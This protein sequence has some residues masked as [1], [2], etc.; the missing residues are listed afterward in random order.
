MRN[1]KQETI[2]VT[3][4][5]GFLGSNVVRAVLDEGYRV[6][7]M[8]EPT[9]HGDALDGLEMETVRGS[10]L[11]AEF[12]SAAVQGTSGVIHTAASTAVWPERIPAMRA[13]NVDAATRI[14]T[15]AR[16]AG[17]RVFVHV[18]TASSF[19]WGPKEKPGDERGAYTSSRFGLDYLD[20]KHE[21]QGLMLA[22]DAPDFRVTVVNPTFMFGPYDSKPSSGAMILAIANQS[23]PGYT[24]GGRSFADVRAVAQGIVSSLE[25]GRG[26]QCYILGGQNLSYKE[27]FSILASVTNA[28]A[29]RL[30]MPGG[31]A[32]AYGALGSACSRVSGKAPQLSLAM[33]RVSLEGQ[34]Y[35]SSKA[36]RELGYQ[37]GNLETAAAAAVAWFKAKGML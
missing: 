11:D 34:Y 10:L 21:A 12:V 6:R 35:D 1:T 9:R 18:G 2:L 13:L 5:D 26:G 3:G 16:N 4:A 28:R 30:R 37:K 29:P 31:I 24:A 27:A 8:V 19:A 33:T 25:R 7:A 20:T 22:L 15:A 23:V 36:E 14:A 17:T 32:L